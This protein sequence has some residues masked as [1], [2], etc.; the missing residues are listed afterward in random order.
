MLF[1]D[2]MAIFFVVLGVLIAFPSL[3]LLC[4]GLFP[5]FV[6]RTEL[7]VHKGYWKS[8]FIGIPVIALSVIL[9]AAV[10]KL[11]AT[12]GQIGG[13]LCFSFLMFFAQTGVAGLATH[14][15][16]RLRSPADIE[17]PWKATLRGGIVLVL[18]YLLPLLGWFFILPLSLIIGAGSSARACFGG[19]AKSV[20]ESH[21]QVSAVAAVSA[22]A[23]AAVSGQGN[24][25]LA[26]SAGL[27]HSAEDAQPE[28]SGKN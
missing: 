10:G 2:T 6:L 20:S 28:T 8:F 11:P 19:K 22:S 15:G 17:R 3:W 25:P 16:K 27:V 9:V 7:A 13:I 18:S 5:N 23:P 24:S 14:V 1:A 26:I 4:S 21:A 12:F